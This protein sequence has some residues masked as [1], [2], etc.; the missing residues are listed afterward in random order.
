MDEDKFYK[1]CFE[2]C[3]FCYGP[4]NETKHQCLECKA[5]YIFLNESL[6][7]YNCYER[8]PYYYYFNEN[9]DYLCIDNCSGVYN[10][11]IIEKDKCIDKCQNDGI[12]KYEYNNTCYER[13]PDDTFYINE[14]GLCLEE[15]YL[16]TSTNTDSQVNDISTNINTEDINIINNTLKFELIIQSNNISINPYYTYII[17]EHISNTNLIQTSNEYFDY[18]NIDDIYDI[19]LNESMFKNIKDNLLKSYAQTEKGKDLEIKSNNILITMTNT[20]NQKNNLEKNKTTINLGDCEN[21]LKIFY[22]ISESSSLIILK[23]DISKEGIIIW[24]LWCLKFNN[25]NY[26]KL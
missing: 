21:K 5:D 18:I 16:E 15:K 2:K 12:Y 9:N 25:Y 13:C 1:E 22:N 26:H 7:N 10:K 20:L 23:M 24:K 14:E 6:F 8:C 3:K 17:N 19:T 11:L 4:G